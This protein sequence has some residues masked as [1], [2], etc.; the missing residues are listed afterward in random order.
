MTVIRGDTRFRR[1]PLPARRRG[2]LSGTSTLEVLVAF[3]LLSSVLSLSVPLVV[4]HGRV[5]TSARQYRLAIEE[6]SDQLERLTALP[7]AQR[8]LALEQ[9]APS[10]FAASRL[11]GA[12]LLGTL[13]AADLGQRLTLQIVWDEPQRRAAPV[14]MAAWILPQPSR[15][16][17]LPA[18]EN[19]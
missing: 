12:E 9:L 17:E 8:Q 7:E 10:Q 13:E 15:A 2:L 16:A 4:R 14:T 19:P 11:P 5:L 3:T 18:Q 6:L 1:F